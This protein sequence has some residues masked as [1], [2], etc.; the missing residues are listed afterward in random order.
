[1][2]S[3]V[4][5]GARRTTTSDFHFSQMICLYSSLKRVSHVIASLAT[6]LTHC[7]LSTL[8]HKC[9]VSVPGLAAVWGP[10]LSGPDQG[11]HGA[12]LGGGVQP[13]YSPFFSQLRVR[14]FC[15]MIS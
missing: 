4:I 2:C 11:H 5:L 10:P 8:L 6:D 12:R 14:P 1:M 13:H 7:C 15:L 9:C 3:Y